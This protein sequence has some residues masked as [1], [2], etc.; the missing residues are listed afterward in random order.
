MCGAVPPLVSLLGM[1]LSNNNNPVTL[2]RERTIPTERQPLVG[3]VSANL[4]RREV[5]RGQRTGSLRP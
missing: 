3:E 4:L 5:S 1:M 2:A